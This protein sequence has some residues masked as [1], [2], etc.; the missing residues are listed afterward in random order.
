MTGVSMY[1]I[2]KNQPKKFLELISE[3]KKVAR[4]KVNTQKFM[5]LPYTSNEQVE[6][7]L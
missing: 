2:F 6:F 1:K 5:A 3:H 4:E 7:K